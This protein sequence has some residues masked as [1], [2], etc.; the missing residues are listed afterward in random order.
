VWDVASP[1]AKL[2]TRAA[3]LRGLALLA[4]CILMMYLLQRAV[5]PKRPTSRPGTGTGIHTGGPLHSAAAQAA[6][7]ASSG[8]SGLGGGDIAGDGRSS[9]DSIDHSEG[10]VEVRGGNSGSREHNRDMHLSDP[11]GVPDG[12]DE[13]MAKLARLEAH[14]ARLEHEREQA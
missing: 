9:Q 13:L 4:V 8:A 7:M 14:V 11:R 6:S 1:D 2:P 12:R 5:N 3:A 10:A